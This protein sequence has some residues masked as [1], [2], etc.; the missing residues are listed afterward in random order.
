MR[1]R[2]G[3][4]GSPKDQVMMPLT[5]CQVFCRPSVC[6]GLQHS[7]ATSDIRGLYIRR[8][9]GLSVSVNE[10]LSLS[11]SFLSSLLSRFVTHSLHDCMYG[12]IFNMLSRKQTGRVC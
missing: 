10:S 4:T 9:K 11:C 8:E 2:A 7:P 3:P 12:N 5:A 1:V 6:T